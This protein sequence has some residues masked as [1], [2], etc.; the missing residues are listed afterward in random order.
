MREKKEK[1]KYIMILLY[2]TSKLGVICYLVSLSLPPIP[3]FIFKTI[4]LLESRI[5]QIVIFN[6]PC[7]F[8]TGSKI[9]LTPML[10]L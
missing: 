1:R 5:N 7:A 2:V 3:L 4:A 9:N 6:W 10:I 8:F